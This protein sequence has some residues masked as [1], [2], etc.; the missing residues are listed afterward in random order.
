MARLKPHYRLIVR[1]KKN[2]GIRAVLAPRKKL[3]AAQRRI[4]HGLLDKI[5]VTA[6]CHGFAKN[7]SIRTN[8]SA[9]VSRE[10]LVQMDIQSFFHQYT[11]KHVSGLFRSLGYPLEVSRALAFLTTAPVRDM[12]AALA[13]QARLNPAQILEATRQGRRSHHPMLPQGAPTSPALA[14][15][16]SR[17]LDCRFHGLAGRFKAEY[18]RYADDIT[19]SGNDEFRRDLRR[20]IPLVK[21]ILK[22]HRLFLA[23]G[24][25]R[26]ARKSRSMRV[27]GLIV[28][29]R[30]NVPIREYR[31]LRAILHNCVTKGPQ[32]QN[33]TRHPKFREH[34]L[35]RIAFVTSVHPEHGA[36][37]KAE[38]DRI[39]WA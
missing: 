28:N 37:L 36:K 34:L 10:I 16:I 27:T 1:P 19:F 29:D 30:V 31:T 3:K 13:K 11:F 18:T 6:W 7:R 24:K 32:T 15:L 25:L 21:K 9:H 20:F 8:A 12:A 38:F 2:G 4:L 39:R 35:G 5:P 14:N 33:R 26:F 17:R 22:D 23:P